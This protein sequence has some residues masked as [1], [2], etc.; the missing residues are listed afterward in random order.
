MKSACI[1]FGLIL[2]IACGRKNTSSSNQPITIMEDLEA[3]VIEPEQDFSFEKAIVSEKKGKQNEVEDLIKL[4][5]QHNLITEA[6]LKELQTENQSQTMVS[7]YSLV[8][9]MQIAILLHTDSLKKPF[10][11]FYQD[12]LDSIL[13]KENR[14]KA[15]VEFTPVDSSHFMEGYLTAQLS[16]THKQKV[17][18]QTLYFEPSSGKLD[19][20]F[21]EII[22]QL[23]AN[24]QETERYYLIRK[25]MEYKDGDAFYYGTNKFDYALIKLNE[26]TAY[27]IHQYSNVL[28]LS[29]E[30]HQLP[31]SIEELIYQINK[32]DSIGLIPNTTSQTQLNKLLSQQNIFDTRDIFYHTLELR[33]C[34]SPNTSNFA[35][36]YKGILDSLST[37]SFQQFMPKKVQDNA[38]PNSDTELSFELKGKTFAVTLSNTIDQIDINTLITTV[39]EAL[40]K[41][42]IDGNYY[43]LPNKDSEFCYIFMKENQVEVVNKL[44]EKN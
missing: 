15:V 12:I 22:N 24:N 17:Y 30:N 38:K 37:I 6:S 26:F 33:K 41:Q 40:N 23:L 5:F 13:Q 8:K 29:Y 20:T 42:N 16:I 14:T 11:Y 4:L 32:L 25:I 36:V 28:D 3:E 2:I 1:F 35:N 34:F 19:E 21:Y 31:V 44:L 10:P 7:N 27:T 43:L 39:N 9:H 18:Q